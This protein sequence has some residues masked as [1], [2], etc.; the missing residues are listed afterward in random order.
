MEG[1]W[2]GGIAVQSVEKEDASHAQDSL[3]TK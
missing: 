1:N 3:H 2:G